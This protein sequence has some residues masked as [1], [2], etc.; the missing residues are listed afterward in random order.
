MKTALDGIGAE[1]QL[2]FIEEARQTL[3][4]VREKLGSD[5]FN[6]DDAEEVCQVL[7][8]VKAIGRNMRS[9]AE[10]YGRHLQRIAETN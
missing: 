1:Q 3:S 7:D 10:T 8:R 5:T 2:R 9:S 4:V 6:D